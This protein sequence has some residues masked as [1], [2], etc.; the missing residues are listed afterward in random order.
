MRSNFHR[1]PVH[2]FIC[3]LSVSEEFQS[4]D[5]ICDLRYAG[6]RPAASSWMIILNGVHKVPDFQVLSPLLVG[7]SDAL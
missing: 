5:I 4:Q 6:L 7:I 3:I 2:E 1:P